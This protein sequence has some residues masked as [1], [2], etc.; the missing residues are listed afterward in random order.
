M[1]MRRPSLILALLAFATTTVLWIRYFIGVSVVQDYH[2]MYALFA[3]VPALFFCLCLAVLSI[4]RTW[5]TWVG[6]I[7]SLPAGALW[8]LSILLILNNNNIKHITSH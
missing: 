6:G 3:F 8:I 2:L 5:A 4:R 7:L 1:A